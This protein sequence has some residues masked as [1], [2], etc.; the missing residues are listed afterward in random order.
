MGFSLIRPLLF[1][2]LAYYNNQMTISPQ[3]LT[4]DLSSIKN[5]MSLLITLHSV[6]N[7]S[8]VSRRWT[9]STPL[10]V[11]TFTSHRM[12]RLNSEDGVPRQYSCVNITKGTFLKLNAVPNHKHRP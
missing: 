3:Y 6:Q 2:V 10:N 11:I 4:Y 7:E 1:K 12:V 9:Y 5:L 8:K